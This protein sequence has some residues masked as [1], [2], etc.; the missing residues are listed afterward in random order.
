[1]HGATQEKF[2]SAEYCRHNL[3]LNVRLHVLVSY[4]YIHFRGAH[5]PND[6]HKHKTH[7]V[8]VLTVT[9]NRNLNIEVHRDQRVAVTVS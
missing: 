3:T 1:M 8:N 9:V 4:S 2:G 6:D 7:H 5:K